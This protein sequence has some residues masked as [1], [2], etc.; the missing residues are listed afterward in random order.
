MTLNIYRVLTLIFDISLELPGLSNI[1]Q[2]D[3]N[4]LAPCQG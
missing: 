1:P 2:T 4:M 3:P